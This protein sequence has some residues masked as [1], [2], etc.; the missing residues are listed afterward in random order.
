MSRKAAYTTLLTRT[1]Y[2]PG[3]LV[4]WYG[5]KSVESK[6]PLVA[7][8]TPDLPK[9]ARD[10]LRKYGIAMW[11]VDTLLPAE[12]RHSVAEHDARFKDTWTKLRAFELVDFERVVMLDS[13]MIVMKN[14]DE[15]MVLPLESDE[16]AAAHVCAC[17]P[18]KIL[19]YP[20]DWVPEN[21]AHTAVK[22]PLSN[23]PS[24]TP[25]GPRPYGQLNS[26]TVVLN[27]SAQLSTAI[28]HYLN[29][30]PLEEFAFPDQD[31]L[32]AF[33]RGKWKA[34][35]W[36]YNALKTLRVI[37]SEEWD[38]DEVRCLHFILRD[39]PW[40][41]RVPATPG[42]FDEVNSWWWQQFDKLGEEI[43]SKDP[44]DWEFISSLVDKQR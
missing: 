15:L 8:V 40:N 39:K 28:V 31:L 6:Y 7:M 14:M 13:D 44:E 9:E 18:M 12:D 33:F 43:K 34:L 37:H 30:Q 27:P 17:N 3:L 16:I 23:P 42:P 36:Y 2:L 5:L 11:E 21:C 20:A 24:W 38:D 41:A 19:H 32:S 1:S 4:L 22:S 26:G 10:I 25:N 29:T 35:P